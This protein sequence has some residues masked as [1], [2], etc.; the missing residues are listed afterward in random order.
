MNNNWHSKTV[1]ETLETLHTN[2]HGLTEKEAAKRLKKYG[3]NKLPEGKVDSIPII[4]L[5][6]FQNPLIYILIAASVIVFA[7][8]ETIDGA[9]I[10]AVL[11]FN[12]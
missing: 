5:R 7:M 2:Q 1:T 3:L 4:F 10:F 9:I 12:A 11:L 6:Q 8:G